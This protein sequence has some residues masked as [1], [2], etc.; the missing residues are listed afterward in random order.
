MQI[1]E[2]WDQRCMVCDEIITN[3]ICSSCI[4]KEIEKWLDEK[5]IELN[6]LGKDNANGNIKCLK[7]GKNID[8]CMYCHIKD[9]ENDII[10]NCPE[11]FGEFIEMFRLFNHT[12]FI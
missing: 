6:L 10:D 5:N 4:N 1:K 7:C 11:L 8:V 2:N 12:I 9:I 3:P